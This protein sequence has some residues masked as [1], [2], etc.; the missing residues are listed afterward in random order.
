MHPG[1]DPPTTTSCNRSRCTS[2][3][4]SL[5]P[6]LTTALHPLQPMPAPDLPIHT[7]LHSPRTTTSAS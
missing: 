6:P 1:T 7:R 3:R 5:S 2:H 4:R